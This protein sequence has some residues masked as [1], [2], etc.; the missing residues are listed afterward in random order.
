MARA[1][2][3][4]DLFSLHADLTAD[5]LSA[6]PDAVADGEAGAEARL[7]A[8]FDANRGPVERCLAILG[9]IRT[10]GTFDLT[11]LPV[12]LREL[13]NLSRSAGAR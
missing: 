13:R 7:E 9:E 8:W 12:A 4:D 10:G 1:A 11:T 6:T 5:I 2:L 3:R